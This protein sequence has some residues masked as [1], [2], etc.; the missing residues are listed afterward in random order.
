MS[1]A[2]HRLSTP[3]FSELAPEFVEL[4]IRAMRYDRAIVSR[5]VE[6][7][8]RAVTTKGFTAFCAH[9]N[10]HILGVTYGSEGS[11]EDWWERQVRRGMRERGGVSDADRA[12]LS[13]YF[14]IE[15]LHV[16]PAVQGRG[17]GKKLLAAI[18]GAQPTPRCLLST[19]EVP[20]EDNAAFGLYRS[21]GF[22]DVLR[23]F[24]FQGDMR[25][26]AVLA[27]SL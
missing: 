14:L 24:Q 23:H 25:T 1:V 17:I 3:E 18:M 13:D 4:Y 22:V 10:T 16:D 15:E 2:I 27:S 8:R 19:P 11:S 6:H 7:W 9:D 12:L 5:R 21:A 20:N 26:F